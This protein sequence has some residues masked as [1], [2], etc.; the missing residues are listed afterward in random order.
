M[1]KYKSKMFKRIGPGGFKC[2]CCNYSRGKLRNSHVG[3]DN[4][5]NKLARLKLKEDMKKDEPTFSDIMQE[6]E[7]IYG[8]LNFEK[9]N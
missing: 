1:D 6:N 8:S 7:Y 3:K 2:S 4:S 5:L 9:G